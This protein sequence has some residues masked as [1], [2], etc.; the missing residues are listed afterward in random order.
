MEKGAAA[1]VL[2]GST[3][4]PRLA[5]V[6][7]LLCRKASI[8][9][10]VATHDS[11][12]CGTASNRHPEVC[13]SQ[14]YCHNCIHARIC[15][16]PLP[17]ADARLLSSRA[18]KFL[19]QLSGV[20]TYPSGARRRAGAS[21]DRAI[22]IAGCDGRRGRRSSIYAQDR[23]GSLKSRALDGG[24]LSYGRV[25]IFS[26]FSSLLCFHRARARAPARVRPRKIDEQ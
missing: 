23:D 15:N 18:F 7:A 10:R 14:S 6:P 16:G 4:G 19:D 8:A 12:C 22:A 20:A 5:S 2:S 11:C 17:N 1:A 3:A 13:A 9:L 21:G 24:R 26:S 25:G